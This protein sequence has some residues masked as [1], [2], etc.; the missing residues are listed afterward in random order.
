MT[1]EKHAKFINKKAVLC[2]RGDF[3][4]FCVVICLIECDLSDFSNSRVVTHTQIKE[5][6]EGNF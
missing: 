6:L 2:C 4:A 1:S 5:R 3:L